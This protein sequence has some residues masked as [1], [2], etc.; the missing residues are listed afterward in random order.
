LFPRT[1]EVRRQDY[2]ALALLAFPSCF[3]PSTKPMPARTSR[4]REAP[5]SRQYLDELR[6][7]VADGQ[8]KG[9]LTT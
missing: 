4:R 5:S 6:A 8:T 9:F 1:S 3:T 7:V 2:A